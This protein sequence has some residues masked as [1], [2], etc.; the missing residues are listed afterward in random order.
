MWLTQFD[1]VLNRIQLDKDQAKQ[2]RTLAV[3]RDTWLDIYP[4]TVVKI[5]IYICG[6]SIQW[7]RL[8]YTYVIFV[9]CVNSVAIIQYTKL[10]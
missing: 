8:K 1:S 9:N 3:G 10:I 5:I 2:T 4:V 7:I 6:K